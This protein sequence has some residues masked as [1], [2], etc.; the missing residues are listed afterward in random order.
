MSQNSN[1]T[2]PPVPLRYL[3]SFVYL[4][5]MQNFAN[6]YFGLDRPISMAQIKVMFNAQVAPTPHI[7]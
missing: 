4:R 5:I 3:V 1:N 7:A 6:L 2:P